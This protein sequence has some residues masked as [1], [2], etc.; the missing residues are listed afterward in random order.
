MKIEK[1]CGRRSDDRCTDRQ[2]WF[3]NLSHVILLQ[4]D[5]Y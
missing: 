2:T 1:N 3:C 4:W 5:R